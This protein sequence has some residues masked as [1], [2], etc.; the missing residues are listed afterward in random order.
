MGTSSSRVQLPLQSILIFFFFIFFFETL[1]QRTTN[2]CGKL[3]LGILSYIILK[4]VN[5]RGSRLIQFWQL[6]NICL[7]RFLFFERNG[8][9]FKPVFMITE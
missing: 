3:L 5:T 9:A 7:M 4:Y 6:N 2:Q 1:V 8:T